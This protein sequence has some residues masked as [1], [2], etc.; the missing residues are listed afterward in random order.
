MRHD[1]AVLSKGVDDGRRTFPNTMKY[2]SIATGANFGNM[3]TRSLRILILTA[4]YRMH[5]AFADVTHDSD[6][7]LDPAIDRGLQP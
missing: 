2:I 4:F 3:I 6:L 5:H 1:L 7:R